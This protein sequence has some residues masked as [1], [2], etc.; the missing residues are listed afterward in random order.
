VLLKSFLGFAL[1]FAIA[2]GV[3]DPL[4]AAPAALGLAACGATGYGLSLRLYVLA[5]RQLG[6]AR[7]GS[8]FATGPFV[9]AV[10]ASTLGEP[11]GGWSAAVA[12]GAMEPGVAL[13]LTER[14]E[15]AHAHEPVEHA[16]AHRHDDGHHDHTHDPMPDGEHSHPHRHDRLVH[17]HPHVPDVHH[18]HEH[19]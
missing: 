5:Q 14:H 15:H 19:E 12:A 10:V 17:A 18:E 13:H 7:T 1:A 2:L 4:P 9:G 3:R 11:L 8:V 6:A 16:H